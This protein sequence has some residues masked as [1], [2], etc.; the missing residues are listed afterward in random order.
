MEQ[1]FLIRHAQSLGNRS[2][3]KQNDVDFPL[4]ELGITQIG[5]LRLDK[6]VDAIFSSPSRR[7][8]ETAKALLPF[9]LRKEIIEDLR[10]KEWRVFPEKKNYLLTEENRK[11][12]SP[13]VL[14]YP[15][16]K[17]YGEG[18]SFEDIQN[19]L[20]RFILDLNTQSYDSV[21]IV[22]HAAAINHLLDLLIFRST[23]DQH[24]D[25]FNRLS[26]IKNSS[27]TKLIKEGNS[28][29]LDYFNH[30]YYED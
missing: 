12:I 17:K 28:F 21:A 7:A 6:K 3:L 16:T 5:N 23:A 14:K 27:V 4:S 26:H 2:K 10:L 1:I 9:S 13:Y 18:E 25:L 24:Y 15:S 19:R 22:S 20:D 11:K 8:V 29:R 30:I